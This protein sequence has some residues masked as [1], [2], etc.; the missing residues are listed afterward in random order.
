[1][2]DRR[3]YTFHEQ[4][5]QGAEGGSLEERKGTFLAAP[6]HETGKAR[7]SDELGFFIT[8]KLAE[9]R[10][11]GSPSRVLG[12]KGTVIWQAHHLLGRKKEKRPKGLAMWREGE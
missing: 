3:S 9:E 4:A 7:G 1:L 2:T 10:L 6:F 8:G 12:K 5:S 11:G